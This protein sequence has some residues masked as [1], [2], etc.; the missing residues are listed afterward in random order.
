MIHGAIEPPWPPIAKPSH[1]NRSCTAPGTLERARLPAKQSPPI[2]GAVIARSARPLARTVLSVTWFPPV[3]QKRSS[4]AGRSSTPYDG[5]SSIRLP[6]IRLSR[7]P[8]TMIP[9]PNAGAHSAE[10]IGAPRYPFAYTWFPAISAPR[11]GAAGSESSVFGTM[12]AALSCHELLTIARFPPAF[13]P[14]Y[15]RRLW[16]ASTSVITA[17]HGLQP[18]M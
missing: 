2:V 5:W 3:G 8:N 17:S 6:V 15:P 9:F 14:E 11:C 13:V 18:P 4:G 7:P 12:P 10:R 1:G 16:A